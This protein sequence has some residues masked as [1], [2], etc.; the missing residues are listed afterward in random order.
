[1]IITAE[2]GDGTLT[3]RG[4]EEYVSDCVILLDHR[5]SEQLS[6]RRLRIVKYRGAMH[7]TNEYPFLIED[8]GFSVLPITSLGLRYKV[9]NERISTG[10]SRLDAMLGGQGVFRGSSVLISGAA[11]TGKT[12][13]AAHFAAAACGRGEC[14]LYF[15]FEESASQLVRNMRSIGLDLAPW[16]E[17]GLLQFHA[18]RPTLS[19]L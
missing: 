15:S 11:G 3:R 16:L 19:G 2:R 5:V 17:S 9:C 7:G 13:L 14:C 1:A 18:S 6:T 10:V 12:S 4:L 8:T